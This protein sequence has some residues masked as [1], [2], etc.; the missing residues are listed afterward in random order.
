MNSIFTMARRA[1]SINKIIPTKRENTLKSVRPIPIF[2]DFT[3]FPLLFAR[4]TTH[5]VNLSRTSVTPLSCLVA[6]IGLVD[7]TSGA[8]PLAHTRCPATMLPRI[9]CTPGTGNAGQTPTIT[10]PWTRSELSTILCRG[11]DMVCIPMPRISTHFPVLD[12]TENGK[13]PSATNVSVAPVSRKILTGVLSA[14]PTSETKASV[15][16]GTY[17][18]PTC[19]SV[20]SETHCPSPEGPGTSQ[21]EPPAGTVKFTCTLFSVR[22]D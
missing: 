10:S 6:S 2:R 16:N 1:F 12:C 14:L 8:D 11:T 20:D 18:S 17:L 3:V 15:M 4:V 5:S 22:K 19:P 21:P 9:T 7:P 13:T